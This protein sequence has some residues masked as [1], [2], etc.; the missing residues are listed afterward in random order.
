[1]LTTITSAAPIMGPVY[2]KSNPATR[3]PWL[4]FRRGGITATEI[5]DWRQGGKRRK[6]I[7]HKV[8]GE[9]ED[10]S[11]VAAVRHGN[12]REPVIG[13]WVLEE[14][15]ITPVNHVFAH[16]DNH[17][18]IASPDGVTLDPFST[19]LVV[20]TADAAI[21]EIKTDSEDLAPGPVDAHRVLIHVT[22]GCKFDKM[23]YYAQIQ[24]GMFVMNAAQ[25]LFVWETHN[26][27]VDPETG[28][29]TPAGPPQYV[30]VPRDQAVIDTLVEMADDA[31]AQIDAARLTAA[32][33]FL[34]EASALP[35]EHAVLV[36]D[37]LAAL[38]AEKIA[39]EKKA[40]AWKALQ[41][42]YLGKPDTSIDAGFAT[43]TTST[44]TP[45]DKRVFDE[46]AA[47]A[48]YP[49]EMEAYANVV[50]EFTTS[51]PQPAKQTLTVR[52]K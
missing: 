45:A 19:E 16:A 39:A 46:E 44:T 27:E 11:Y 15:G 8:T 1:M 9:D 18:Y 37:Y 23:G 4:D 28:T 14:F 17:R 2:D 30:W 35:A 10:I 42:E 36:A 25:C 3:Q 24:W 52:R 49:A 31:L 40:I 38:D 50:A 29:Y 5:R 22:S 47:R 51:T 32:G 43:L 41:G 7:A 48:K 20:G 26:G 33:E 21:L 6:I 12:L 34:P 13:E